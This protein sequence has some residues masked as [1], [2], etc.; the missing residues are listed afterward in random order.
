MRPEAVAAM[1]P[2]LSD[3]PGNPSGGHAVARVAKTALEEARESVAAILGCAPGEIVFTGGGT[4]ADNLAVKGAARARRAAGRDGVVTSAIEHKGVLAAAQRL[5]TEGFRVATIGVGPGGVIDLDRLEAALDE[6][7]AVVSVMLVNNEVGT[8]Q[9]LAEVAAR[10]RSRAPHAVL[11]TDAVQAVPWLDVAEPVAGFDLVAISGHKFGGP[12]GVGVLVVRNGV[13][14]QPE[15]EGGGQERGL[16]AGTVNVAGA[17]ALATALRVTHDRRRMDVERVRVL[18]D[19]LQRGLADAVPSLFFNGEADQKVAGN[20][21]IG[22]TGVESEA[23]LLT[24]DAAGV[25]AAAGSSCSSGATEP[26]H[27]LEAMGLSR[28]CSRVRPVQPRLRV[29]E[30]GRRDGARRHPA[31]RRAPAFGRGMTERVLVAMSGGVDSSV[32]AALLVEAGHDVTGVTLKLWGGESDSGCCSVA[33]VEDARRV[34][35]QLGIPHYVF[36][37]TE[38]FDANVVTPYTDAYAAGRTPNPC[39]EC[40]R[41]MKFGRLLDRGMAMG[42]D[43]V[44]TGHHA[45][46]AAR[47]TRSSGAG[48]GGRRRQGPVLRALHAASGRAG[49]GAAAGG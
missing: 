43:A 3:H 17:V 10:V 29:D 46:I 5:G 11:H 38:D 41:T 47:R 30:L 22:F 48:P 21:H 19:R 32:A 34:A 35:A 37:F 39:V 14:L 7:T 9:P 25:Y 45:R 20:L 2:F 18:R 27:V 44:A 12:K 42:F 36:N 28:R 49:A 33:D 16:R 26:S 23:L 40:N 8:I 15:I 13:T 24:L 31:C 4:E 1:L 6:R